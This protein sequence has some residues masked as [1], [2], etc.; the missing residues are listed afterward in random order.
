MRPSAWLRAEYARKGAR[1]IAKELGCSHD[2]VYEALH[3]AGI[4]MRA[5]GFYPK[6]PRQIP[7]EVAE[8]AV[9]LYLDG[10]SVKAVA[11]ELGLQVQHVSRLIEER[12]AQALAR[13]GGSAGGAWAGRLTSK[14][15]AG[16]AGGRG[17]RALCGRRV[18]REDCTLSCGS[19]SLG[20]AQSSV[21]RVLEDCTLSRCSGVLRSHVEAS[22]VRK[23]GGHPP[24][25][26]VKVLGIL[27]AEVV[28]QAIALYLAG[29][30]TRLIGRARGVPA[31]RVYLALRER[32]VVRTR[33]EARTVAHARVRSANGQ[34]GAAVELPAGWEAV[35]VE[36]Y[37]GGESGPAITNGLGLPVGRVYGVAIIKRDVAGSPDKRSLTPWGC[38]SRARINC[39]ADTGCCGQRA[40]RATWRKPGRGVQAAHAE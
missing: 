1:R 25:A 32:G 12:G 4:E 36:R 24:D 9:S 11:G 26:S 7:P 21:Y 23:E 15:V 17:A 39:C 31:A 28:E 34:D 37:V 22:R 30:S 13:R 10:S 19:G 2:R 38:V 35:V 3:A 20:L 33:S 40:R 14:R 29:D 27:P 6:P 8:P 16:G 18:G 5:N